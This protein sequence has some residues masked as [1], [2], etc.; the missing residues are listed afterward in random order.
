MEGV[1]SGVVFAKDIE[2]CGSAQGLQLQN[3]IDAVSQDLTSTWRK[4]NGN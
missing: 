4:S 3:D 1:F 2:F